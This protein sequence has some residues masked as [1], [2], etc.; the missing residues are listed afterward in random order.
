MYTDN[1]LF[2]FRNRENL[3]TN[4][5]FK[6]SLSVWRQPVVGSILKVGVSYQAYDSPNDWWHDGAWAYVFMFGNLPTGEA[7]ELMRDCWGDRE[8][9]MVREL[10][11]R[12][13]KQ[14]LAFS[15]E[16]AGQQCVDDIMFPLLDQPLDI[17]QAGDVGG[18]KEYN[19]KSA[20]DSINDGTHSYFPNTQNVHESWKTMTSDK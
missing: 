2:T 9:N 11:K 6:A 20:L 12:S 1:Q 14:L 16:I 7:H 17:W 15:P 18:Y 8:V 13:D 19:I 5:N 10:M 4:V 3:V